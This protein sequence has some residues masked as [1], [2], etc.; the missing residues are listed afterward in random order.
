MSII[1]PSQLRSGSYSISGSFSGS[2]HGNGTGVTGVIS[3]S[4][5][6]NSDLLDGRDSTTYANTGS[7][8]FVGQQVITGSV[9]VT[10]S[11][12]ISDSLNVTSATGSFTG[13]FT[14]NG[15]GL[16]SGSFSGSISSNLQEVTNNGSTTTNAITSSGIQTND[17][18]LI[19]NGTVTGSFIISGSNTFKNIGPAQFTGSVNITGS[20]ILNS[21]PLVTEAVYNPFTA[22]YYQD[23]ASFNTRI[24]NNSSSIALLS[25]SYEAFTDTYNTGSFTG[26]FIGS[27]F[28]T[29]S[30]ATNAL[31]A[32]FIT[33]SNVFGPYGSNSVI[34]ASYALTA[35]YA[36]NGGT[37][38]IDTGSLLTTASIS[39]DTITFT[40]G[41][42]ST[43]PIVVPTGSSGPTPG[44][45]L[46]G[47]FG[48]TV[49][50]AGSAITTGNKGYVVVPYGG[51]ITGWTLIAD[52]SGS[53]VIDV[54]KAAGTI[55]ALSDSITGTEKPTLASQQ[56]N[57][58]INLTTWTSSVSPGDIFA[59]NVDSAST[60]TRV[61]LSIYITKQ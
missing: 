31:S 34:S 29:A 48:V 7:N 12:T 18:Y 6:Q 41:N 44:G 50:G 33:A 20:G 38:T 40:K 55:P 59:F 32:S 14:G 37:G 61:N 5:A 36:L 21:F 49:D 51:T 28:G 26:S 27:L 60:L 17:F 35:S 2:F 47:S 42:G 16:F 10:G 45:V 4:Y 53:C 54:W 58:D 11:Q 25:S 22:S 8:V 23:S 56:I 15:S 24:L 39:G 52:Q 19:G 57:S 13:S 3:S 1:K 46:S 30:W 9:F 43:F